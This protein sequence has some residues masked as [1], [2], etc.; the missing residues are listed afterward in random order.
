MYPMGYEEFKKKLLNIFS[1]ENDYELY[2]EEAK[3]EFIKNHKFDFH[4]IYKIECDYY[5]SGAT[6]VFENTEL[7]S[8]YT[9][10]LTE[11]CYAYCKEHN[12]LLPIEKVDE[13][14]YPMNYEEFLRVLRELIIKDALKR[15]VPLN[16]VQEFIDKEY[17]LGTD[18]EY[19]CY[20]ESC[21]YY[22]IY[23]LENNPAADNIFTPEAI[24]SYHVVGINN[25]TFLF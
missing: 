1:N 11:D 14:K 13:S 18:D 23:K 25:V 5:D 10:G 4:E 15:N 22:D 2:P 17:R 7:F 19:N 24:Q 20:K 6:N 9:L 3:Q 8:E 21:K 12:L 16:E